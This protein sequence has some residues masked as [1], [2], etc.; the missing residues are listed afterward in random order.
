VEESRHLALV[1]LPA[2]A[3]LTTDDQF[4]VS[5]LDL[6]EVSGVETSDQTTDVAAVPAIDATSERLEG[7]GLKSGLAGVIGGGHLV[8]PGRS[9]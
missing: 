1:G 3:A 6:L 9:C 4:G 2:G 8:L 5:R 7:A